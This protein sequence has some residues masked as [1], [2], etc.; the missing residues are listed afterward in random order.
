MRL[1]RQLLYVHIRIGIEIENDGN[2][3][4]IQFA[5]LNLP[6]WRATSWSA[7]C[8]KIAIVAIQM[9]HVPKWIAFGFA[10]LLAWTDGVHADRAFHGF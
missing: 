4:P 10:E 9:A 7:R 3:N 8:L 1:I 6:A 5:D 2:T